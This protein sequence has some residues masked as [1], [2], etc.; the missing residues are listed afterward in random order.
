M[1]APVPSRRCART[2]GRWTDPG[3]SPG[4]SSRPRSASPSTTSRLSVVTL[5]LPIWPAIFMPL[6]TRAGVA[7]APIEPGTRWLL[8]LPCDAPW[9]EKLWRFI[10]PAKP[11]PL[12]MPVTSTRSPAANTS[13]AMICPSSKPGEVV[14]AQLGEV[15]LRRT[16]RGL[17]VAELRLVQTRGLGLT[18]RDLHG[19]VAVALGRPELHDATRSGLDDAHR[20]DPV[21]IV[22]D[23]GHAELSA[24]NPFL[25]HRSPL[26]RVGSRRSDLGSF[27][28]RE[29]SARAI[30]AER[31]SVVPRGSP[32]ARGLR[33]P[34]LTSRTARG[35]GASHVDHAIVVR[36]AR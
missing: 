19:R 34:R 22:E 20:Y 2:R 33:G 13:A 3:S 29:R 6:N 8:W 18:E 9:P 27:D 4:S 10:T 16:A 5:A 17:E 25:R 11:L 15:L 32:M 7:H 14:D 36:R 12:L 35:W 31:D 24:Q 30:P 1:R 23:L 26:M 28:S 21:R